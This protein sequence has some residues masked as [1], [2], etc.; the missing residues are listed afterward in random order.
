[1]GNV[2]PEFNVID[3]VWARAIPQ[4]GREFIEAAKTEPE[5]RFM[6]NIRYR[7]DLTPD[8]RLTHDG[9]V[10][11]ILA[12]MDIEERHIEQNIL[13]NEVPR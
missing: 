8:H 2:L 9:R 5:L 10:M 3:T 6:W 7:A 1:M 13:C 11:N 4:T 12:V